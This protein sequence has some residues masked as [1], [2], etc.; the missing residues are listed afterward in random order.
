MTS[1][2]PRVLVLTSFGLIKNTFGIF[3]HPHVPGLAVGLDGNAYT[4]WGPSH[5]R[6][7]TIIK[8]GM[9]HEALAEILCTEITYS[10]NQQIV[11]DQPSW[12]V[13]GFAS[14]DEAIVYVNRFKV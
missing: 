1:F 2:D 9:D 6:P 13:A 12:K 3:T 4:V 14:E 8:D 7:H 10:V 11:L 5:T